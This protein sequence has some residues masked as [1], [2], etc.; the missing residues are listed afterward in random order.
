MS[1]KKNYCRGNRWARFK[2][3]WLVCSIFFYVTGKIWIH[4]FYYSIKRMGRLGFRVKQP[5]QAPHTHLCETVGHLWRIGGF[6][7]S[8]AT[9]FLESA[10][11]LS[12]NGSPLKLKSLRNNMKQDRMC[13]FEFNR[14]VKFVYPCFSWPG[15]RGKIIRLAPGGLASGSTFQLFKRTKTFQLFKRTKSLHCPRYILREMPTKLS[16]FQA[17]LG[18]RFFRIPSYIWNLVIKSLITKWIKTL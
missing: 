12:R 11:Y 15:W 10:K 18:Q 1:V 9:S 2:C 17:L 3:E 16:I 7:N 13:W 4:F 8:R 5:V 14:H 6:S